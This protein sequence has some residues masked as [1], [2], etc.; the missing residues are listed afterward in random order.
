MSRLAEF[1]ALEH[2]VTELKSLKL[3]PALTQGRTMP[4]V[5]IFK[6][7]ISVNALRELHHH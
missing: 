2:L 3:Y 4:H 1:R 5:I 7:H 6:H